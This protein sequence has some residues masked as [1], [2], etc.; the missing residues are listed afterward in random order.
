M[1]KPC[2]SL[3][4]FT[5]PS[6]STALPVNQP[7]IAPTKIRIKIFTKPPRLRGNDP[8]K[9]YSSSDDDSIAPETMYS[10]ATPNCFGVDPCHGRSNHSPCKPS[11]LLN[12]RL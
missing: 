9:A 2:P 6:A 7:A 8:E 1:S 12:L 11:V 10:W 5:R 3:T 4:T